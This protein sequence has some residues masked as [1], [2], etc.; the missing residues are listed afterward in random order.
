MIDL[1]GRPY[2]DVRK[3]LNSFLPAG[4]DDAIAERLVDHQLARLAEDVTLHDKVEFE[5]AVTCW[6]F[7]V[8]ESRARLADAGLDNGA[9]KTTAVIQS[10]ASKVHKD[11]HADLGKQ[12]TKIEVPKGVTING[13]EQRSQR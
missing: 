3:S 1:H 13:V 6:D 9:V 7:S 5:I 10:D 4:I 2:I 8:D 11:A 12:Y